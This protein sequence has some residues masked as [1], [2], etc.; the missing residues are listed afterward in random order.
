[1]LRAGVLIF[2]GEFAPNLTYPC[3]AATRTA[4]LT[5]VTFLTSPVFL[6]FRFETQKRINRVS[7]V[8]AKGISISHQL[9]VDYFI[10]SGVQK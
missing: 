4:L 9:A 2:L 5:V 10:C 8:S 1:M 7:K 6:P 3:Q